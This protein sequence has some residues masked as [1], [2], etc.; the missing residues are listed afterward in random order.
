MATAS[1]LR[2]AHTDIQVHRQRH[3]S[4]ANLLGPIRAQR[5]LRDVNGGVDVDP[6]HGGGQ[7]EVETGR[8]EDCGF[9]DPA[10]TRKSSASMK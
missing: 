10:R 5:L 8:Q 3:S 9:G 4:N 6:Q 7:H 2:W 1:A